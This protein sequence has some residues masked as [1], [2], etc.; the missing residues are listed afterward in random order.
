MIVKQTEFIKSATKPAHYPEG[1][2]PEIAFAGR[3][4]VGKSSLVNVLVNR[5]NLVR[6]SSTPGR[7]QLINFFQV[8]DD[9]MLVDLPGYGYAKVPLAV[10]KEWRP[11]M[12]TYLSKRRNLRGVVLILDIRRTPTEEDLQ[13][14]AWLRAFS[15]PPIVVITKCD[16]VSKNERARQ[17]AVIM[18]KM[19]LKKEELNYFSALSKEGKDAVW[20]RIDA[21]LSPAAAETTE[22]S[23]D[24]APSAPV[25]D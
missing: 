16:K 2:L 17:S 18:E 8:N 4:N 7:T 15:V 22:I 11:M 13:M 20:A 1:N 25:N 24:P 23:G 9:F 19:Q 5:K 3:S 14:L 6:T 21:L 12:E 10:K